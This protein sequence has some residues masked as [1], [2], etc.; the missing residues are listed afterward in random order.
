MVAYVVM[1]DK[2]VCT[3]AGDNDA[4]VN[5]QFQVG[6]YHLIKRSHSLL[7]G[8]CS[9][10]PDIVTSPEHY[11]WR[12]TRVL[13]RGNVPLPLDT[14]VAPGIVFEV[15][16]VQLDILEKGSYVQNQYKTAMKELVANE[17]KS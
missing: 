10:C 3:L 8:E 15:E 4:R 14:P 2:T 13:G 1:P 7:P 5:F 9:A 11:V 17:T 12:A 16:E 6:R